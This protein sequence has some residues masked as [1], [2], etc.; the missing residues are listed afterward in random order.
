MVFHYFGRK[1]IPKQDTEP[2]IPLYPDIKD[3]KR[4]D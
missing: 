1:I 4:F 2:I 3:I